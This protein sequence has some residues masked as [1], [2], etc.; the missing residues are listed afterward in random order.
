MCNLQLMGGVVAVFTTFIIW[1][2]QIYGSISAKLKTF[3]WPKGGA[4]GPHVGL[5]PK[6]DGHCH[7]NKYTEDHLSFCGILTSEG[8]N[9]NIYLL[10]VYMHRKRNA[11]ILI[12]Y[13]LLRY[14]PLANHIKTIW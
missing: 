13:L 7:L 2:N 3:L 12:L 1:L 14:L 9:V 8:E 11:V 10:R 5:G 4:Q 6:G